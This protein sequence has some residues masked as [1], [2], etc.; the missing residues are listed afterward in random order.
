M[1]LIAFL[2]LLFSLMLLTWC[3]SCDNACYEAKA[4]YQEQVRLTEQAQAEQ[5]RLN[6]AHY[7]KLELERMQSPEYRETLRLE[8]EQRQAAALEEQANDVGY[9]SDSQKVR[10]GIAV[11]S[12]LFGVL[13]E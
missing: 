12:F 11:A 1:R 4:K 5:V 10:D 8:T 6:E 3:T 7:A 13:W 9:M 2:L